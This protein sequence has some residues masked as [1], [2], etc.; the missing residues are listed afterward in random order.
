M[1]VIGRSMGSGRRVLSSSG[2]KSCLGR[3]VLR[4]MVKE[5]EEDGERWIARE[6]DG[7][8]GNG[9]GKGCREGDGGE[10]G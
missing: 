10:E 8:R 7:E 1:A 4:R 6:R 2:R 3:D 5:K 9:E